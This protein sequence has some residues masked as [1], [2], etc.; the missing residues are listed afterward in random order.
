MPMKKKTARKT[1]RETKETPV[2]QPIIP[3]KIEFEDV[4]PESEPPA[5][6]AAPEPP[7]QAPEEKRSG[8]KTI[9]VLALLVLAAAL[10]YYF[11]LMPPSFRA[12][13]E[14]DA[15]TF[16][17][18]FAASQNVYI[19]MDVRGIS[20]YNVSNNVMQCGVDFAASSGMGGKNATYLSFGPNSQ[21]NTACVASDGNEYPVEDCLKMLDGGIAIY[22]KEC[23]AQF[24]ILGQQCPGGVKYYSN[25]MVVS[26]GNNYALGTC[27][28][29]KV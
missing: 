18:Q 1:K 11:L 17:D 12:G 28:I 5:G 21:G 7:K 19:V 14:V 6:P 13:A 3:E 8:L 2:P 24:A 16:K 9:A 4:K 29:H 27:G 15:E 10:A 23:R 22:V 26:V 25:G 20:D